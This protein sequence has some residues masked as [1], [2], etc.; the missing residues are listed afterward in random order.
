MATLADCRDLV[1]GF[2]G[3]LDPYQVS[4]VYLNARINEFYTVDF[5][6]RIQLEEEFQSFDLTVLPGQDRYPLDSNF[7]EFEPPLSIDGRYLKFYEDKAAFYRD[8]KTPFAT[9][10]KGPSDG[11]TT[12][13]TMILPFPIVDGTLIVI[14][15]AETFR[16]LGGGNLRSTLGGTGTYDPLTRLAT[17]TFSRALVLNEYIRFT[18]QLA[19]AG[20]PR[21]A[22]VEKGALVIRP[23]PDTSYLIQGQWYLRSSPLVNDTDVFP[24]PE[25]LR[26]VAYGAAAKVFEENGELDQSER[27]AKFLEREKCLA[28]SRSNNSLI[29]GPT[30]R[31]F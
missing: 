4:D 2:T 13:V 12:A 5:P 7:I 27:I 9:F 3:R 15:L 10:L 8:F 26:Y 16:D 1:R 19:T 29:A 18:Y 20:T 14:S 17:L 11:G 22:V 24:Y 21:A 31:S 25:W 23:V 28:M 30:M 6:A